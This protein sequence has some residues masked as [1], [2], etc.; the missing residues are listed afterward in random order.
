LDGED[1]RVQHHCL[2]ETS[3]ISD[4]STCW[5]YGNK[6]VA[7]KALYLFLSALLLTVVMQRG[8]NEHRGEAEQLTQLQLVLWNMIGDSG[9]LL[10][11]LSLSE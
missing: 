2:L 7:E 4:A 5:T 1:G 8:Y 11:A 10:N 9:D 3:E 6:S